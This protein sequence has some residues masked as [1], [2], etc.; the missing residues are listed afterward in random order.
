MNIVYKLRILLTSSI[1]LLLS[2]TLPANAEPYLA[3]KNNMLCSGCHVNPV[4]GGARN[5]YGAYYGTNV[6]PQTAGSLTQFDSG[7]ITEGLRI[8]ANFRANYTQTDIKKGEDTRTFETQSGQ[9][10][11]ILQPKDSRFS[12]YIDEQLA[13]GGAIN[14]EAF[15]MTK[16]SASSSLKVGKLMLPYGIR[17]E[18]DTAFIR[19]ST[20]FNFDNSDNGV[21]W[22]WQKD[23]TFISAA[24]SNGSSGLTNNDKGMS[25]LTRVEYLGNNWRAGASGVLNDAE[26]GARY[27]ANIFGGF[28]WLG[29]T[30]LVEMDHIKDKSISHI[31]GKYE[32]QRISFVEVNREITKGL[33]VKVTTEYLDPETNVDENERVRHSLLMEYTPFANMQIR[34]GL[35][36]GK[37]IPQKVNGNYTNLFVQMHLYY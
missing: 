13:P 26:L 1:F 22:D 14:R 20:G 17:L 29:F 36:D 4:G 9:L 25:Y 33:N 8:G 27:Q 28:N 19:Q 3:V 23:R 15:I 30:F 35:R 31:A 11:F 7:N 6:L 34:G 10:Y 24:I 12:L 21:E 16:L 32:E 2:F 5:S 18:D 37:D